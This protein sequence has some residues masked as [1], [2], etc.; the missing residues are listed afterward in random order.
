M[1]SK[2]QLMESKML[3]KLENIKNFLE[4][5]DIT[6]LTKY[7]DKFKPNVKNDEDF[8]D[9]IAEIKDKNY[10]Q[11]LFLTE[12]FI[13]DLKEKEF[14]EEFEDSLMDDYSDNYEGKDDFPYENIEEGLDGLNTD[15]MDDMSF[16]EDL[17]ED[18]Y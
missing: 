4:N 8:Q 1:K 17:D 10:D 15:Q 13:Y 7:I 5:D 11:A 18:Y 3:E 12:E 16:Y 2:W 14:N 6:G 9:I